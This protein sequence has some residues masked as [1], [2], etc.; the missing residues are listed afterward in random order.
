M[1][2]LIHNLGLDWKLFLAQAVNFLIVIV[3]LRFTVYR[4][5]LHLMAQ[6]RKK[7][8]EGLAK[9][10]E[11]ERRLLEVGELKKNKL[12]EAE[13]E[14]VQVMKSA[15][16]RAKEETQ[17]ILAAAAKKEAEVMKT[18]LERIEAEKIAERK[19]LHEEAVSLVKKVIAKP[20]AAVAKNS[21][22]LPESAGRSCSW[23]D[24]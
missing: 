7:I 10:E 18:A 3:I 20:V 19:K 22:N 1:Q 21:E 11:A 2:E 6:R 23:T 17:K 16:A 5:L 8:E 24:G 4:P 9:S 15:E 14:V 12:K 13:A